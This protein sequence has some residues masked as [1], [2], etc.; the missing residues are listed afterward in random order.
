M[1]KR[2]TGTPFGFA[3]RFD[4]RRSQTDYKHQLGAAWDSA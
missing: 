2:S 3:E 1:E 4:P